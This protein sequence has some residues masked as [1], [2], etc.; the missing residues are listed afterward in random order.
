MAI[1]DKFDF[2][3]LS[4]DEKCILAHELLLEVERESENA[5]LTPEQA[6]ELDRRVALLD[7]GQTELHDWED[8]KKSLWPE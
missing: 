3:T 6:A 8:V 7:A 5:P 4:L 1:R 2:S